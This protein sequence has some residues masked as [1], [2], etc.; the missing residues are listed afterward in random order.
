LEVLRL[1][2]QTQKTVVR[3]VF[4]DFDRSCEPVREF[5]NRS[6]MAF[7]QMPESRRIASSCHFKQKFVCVSFRQSALV[8]VGTAS[9]QYYRQTSKRYALPSKPRRLGRKLEIPSL[10]TVGAR[11]RF[12]G[13]NYPDAVNPVQTMALDAFKCQTV[14]DKISRI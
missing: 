12:A 10:K 2:Y 6:P 3:Y 7:V 13:Y 1:P 4:S 5:E 14:D 11:S 9:Y 8:S